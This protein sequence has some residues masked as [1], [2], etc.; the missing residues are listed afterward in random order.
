MYKE[1]RSQMRF[2]FV[3][4]MESWSNKPLEVGAKVSTLYTG[5]ALCKKLFCCTKNYINLI[6]S[7]NQ[8]LL[9]ILEK[10]ISPGCSMYHNKFNTQ[11]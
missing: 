1:K 10:V 2:L 9:L 8:F 11:Y 6:L 4:C 3:S 7:T 5:D